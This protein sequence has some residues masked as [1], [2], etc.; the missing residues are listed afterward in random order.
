[1]EAR[2]LP[3]GRPAKLTLLGLRRGLAGLRRVC[4]WRR[5]G[6]WIRGPVLCIWL[7]LLGR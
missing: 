7:L 2:P 5:A 3:R 1:M 6:G 4:R